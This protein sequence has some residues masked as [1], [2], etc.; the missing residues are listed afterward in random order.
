MSCRI[1][2]ASPR[3]GGD[4][5][6]ACTASSLPGGIT[7][8]NTGAIS[9]TSSDRCRR[10]TTN[11]P[12]PEYASICWHSPAAAPAADSTFRR[13]S[14]AGPSGRCSRA[15]PAFPRMV[16]S[17]LLKSCATPPAI[18]PSD[19]S[20]CACSSCRSTVRRPSSARW[21]SVTSMPMPAANHRPSSARRGNFTLCHVTG[22]PSGPAMVSYMSTTCRPAITRRSLA[23]NR[24]ATSAGH[25]SVT[26]R[27]IN[28]SAGLRV[29]RWYSGLAYTYRLDSSRSQ[30]GNGAN[31]PNRVNPST[32]AGRAGGSRVTSTQPVPAIGWHRARTVTPHAVTS[33]AAGR[34]ATA[35]A[36]AW[37]QPS[38]GV[39]GRRSG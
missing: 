36:T 37:C 2:A 28:C 19:S 4:G 38:A 33:R 31:W 23:V 35:A 8:R 10:P 16:V 9:R 25:M 18:T 26:A 13:Q 11:C 39:T 3:T 21:R 17:R 7:D 6:S 14:A 15:S 24:S 30:V 1:W 29:A 32:T 12:R 20:F 27:P 34:P 5:S 22:V